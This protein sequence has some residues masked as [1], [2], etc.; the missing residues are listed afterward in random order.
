MGTREER[1]WGHRANV[2]PGTHRAL[3]DHCHPF[4]LLHEAEVLPQ[5]PSP[6]PRPQEPRVLLGGAA[7][8]GGGGLG[9]GLGAGGRAHPGDAGTCGVTPGTLKVQIGEKTPKTPRSCALQIRPAGPPP[10]PAPCRDEGTGQGHAGGG[11]E[12]G[13]PA[14]ATAQAGYTSLRTSQLRTGTAQCTDGSRS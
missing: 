7:G 11:P 1:S 13:S 3:Q 5:V 12:G 9:Q 8:S 14:G 2:G 10:C 6:A 4:L